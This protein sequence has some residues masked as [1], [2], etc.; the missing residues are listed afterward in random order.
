[1]E[2]IRKIIKALE[3]S[4]LLLK[5]ISETIK[6]EAKKQKG[7]FPRILAATLL[8]SVLEQVAGQLEL[9]KLFNTVSSFN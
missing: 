8:G 6:N 4:G 1:M 2:D 7:E 3:E 5:G 9:V